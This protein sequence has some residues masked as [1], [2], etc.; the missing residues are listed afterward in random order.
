MP[1]T[2]AN[3]NSRYMVEGEQGGEDHF[4][5]PVLSSDDDSNPSETSLDDACESFCLTSTPNWAQGRIITLDLGAYS[6]AGVGCIRGVQ[7]DPSTTRLR[8]TQGELIGVVGGIVGRR[9]VKGDA[10]ML[11]KK[12]KA[13]PPN[14][15]RPDIRAVHGAKA[16]EAKEEM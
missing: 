5:V 15:H 9:L 6:K 8:H 16:G 2:Q 3:P 4:H 14:R 12:R 13:W 11:T 7:H 1:S 10:K